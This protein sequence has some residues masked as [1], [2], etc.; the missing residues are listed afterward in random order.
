MTTPADELR[1]A[2][3]K[4]RAATPAEPAMIR[5]YEP[6][7]DWLEAEKW[8]WG[9]GHTDH[10]FCPTNRCPQKAALAVARAINGSQP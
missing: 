2:A 3:D 10:T 1:T 4:L 7:A 6:L 8:A 9:I 5:A